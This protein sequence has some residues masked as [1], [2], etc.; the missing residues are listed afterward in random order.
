[1]GLAKR[2]SRPQG[3]TPSFKAA[4]SSGARVATADQTCLLLASSSASLLA[5]S[6]S[7]ALHN[8][9]KQRERRSLHRQLKLDHA[10]NRSSNQRPPEA[11]QTGH[12]YKILGSDESV[13][14]HPTARHQPSCKGYCGRR[15]TLRL[16][17]RQ[18][19]QSRPKGL[20]PHKKKQ[21]AHPALASKRSIRLAFFSP[22]PRPSFWPPPPP[23]AP[24]AT[25]R[26]SG[27]F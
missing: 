14:P 16:A 21:Q 13:I 17:R 9:K 5:A 23:P 26:R 2:Q 19:R 22:P 1:M 10:R 6:S 25:Q 3:L 4:D 27:K 15:K 20:T 24:C 12:K 11:K 7:S 8:T 18:S